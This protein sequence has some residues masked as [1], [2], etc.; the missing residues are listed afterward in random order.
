MN[1]FFDYLI[2]SLLKISNVETL[3]LLV[4][5]ILITNPFNKA[6]RNF[7]AFVN[8][9]SADI[10]DNK[11][12]ADS[13]CRLAYFLFFVIGYN[14][15]PPT[16]FTTKFFFAFIF[17]FI[18]CS[19]IFSRLAYSALTLREANIKLTFQTKIEKKLKRMI[20]I[21]KSHVINVVIQRYAPFLQHLAFC[22]FK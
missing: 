14:I 1:Y 5:A 18:C 15:C 17:P 21:T 22:T 2:D 19:M 10:F 7:Y 9:I 20:R 16:T 13:L 11:V 12:N 4:I 8:D 3:F 6:G